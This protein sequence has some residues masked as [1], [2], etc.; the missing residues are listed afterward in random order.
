VL[1]VGESLSGEDS[2]VAEL[3]SLDLPEEAALA[4]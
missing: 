2:A 3:I 1:G 4:G